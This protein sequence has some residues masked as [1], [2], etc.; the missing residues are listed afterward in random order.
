MTRLPTSIVSV[1]ALLFSILIS[2]G[3]SAESLRL[4]WYPSGYGGG[5]RFTTIAV[6]PSDPRTVYVG[7]DVAGVF[8][9]RDGGDSFTLIGKGLGGFA[10][11]DIAVNPAPP[12]QVVAL[13][14]DGLY[15]SVNR[16]DDWTRIPGDIRYTSRY[17]GSRLLLF[18]RDSLWVGTD[19]K[20]VFKLP[21]S[22]LKASPQPVPGLERFKVNGLA[23]YDG[24]VYAGTTG[25]VFRLEGLEWKPQ[26]QGLSPGAAEI[27]DIASSRKVLY[28]VEKHGGLF[29]WNET[30]RAWENRSASMTPKSKS[31]KSHFVYKSLF[32]HPDNPELV[33]VGSH[34]EIWPIRLNKTQNGGATWEFPSSFQADPE[35]PRNWTNT[36]ASLEEMTAFPGAPSTLFLA[37]R[38]NLWRSSDGGE[39][40]HQRHVG[41]QNTC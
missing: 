9:S 5:G 40:W 8:R 11:A 39:S 1:A 4:S 22:D 17:F 7:S 27:T 6:D 31:Y 37:D 18:T 10:T 2:I 33:F 23:V 34:P 41:L 30:N 36:L 13:L 12:H 35:A 38:W 21:L 25:G 20:G 19:A 16:G 32:V 29:R 15:L 26:S 28:L 3:A 24:Y 14:D